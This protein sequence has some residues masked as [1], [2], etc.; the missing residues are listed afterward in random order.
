MSPR[1]ETVYW[2]EYVIRHGKNV[3]RSPA[4]D[5]EWWQVELLDVYAFIA[6]SVAAALFAAIFVAVKLARLG[7]SFSR[8]FSETSAHCSSKKKN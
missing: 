4:V 3:L 6:A 7:L 1:E 2:V 8:R 5:M